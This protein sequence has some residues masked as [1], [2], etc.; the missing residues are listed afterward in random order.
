MKLVAALGLLLLM[1]AGAA[2]AETK[3]A[4]TVDLPNDV[5]TMD[6]Q[7]QWDTDSYSV[8]RNVFDN[9]VSRHASGTIVRQIATAWHYVNDRTIVFDLRSDVHF[10]DGSKLTPNDVVFSIARITNPAFHSPQLSQFDQIA[11][12][13][14]SGPAQVTLHTKRP[15][16]VLLAQLVKL[17]II[18]K[19]Y[20]QKVGDGGLN[21]HPIGSGPY[22]LRSWQHGVQSVLDANPSYWRG[23]P[24]FQ[25]VIFR[26]VP[27]ESTRVADLRAGHADIIR[28][29]SPD[30]AQALK[31]D[32]QLQV[33]ATPTERLGYLF[34]NT[35]WGP[36]KDLRVRQAMALAIDREA[37]ISALLEGY[38]KP[39][40]EMLTPASFGYG[41]A[42]KPWPFDPRRARALIAEAHAKGA[43]LTFLTSPAYD[44]RITEA[45]QQMLSD[46]GLTVKI[47][48]VDMPTFLHDREGTPAAAQSLA[49]GRWSCACQDADGTIW[50]LFHSGIIW[51][52]YSNPAFDKL[53]DAARGTLDPKQ[54]LADYVQAFAILHHDVPAV[55]LFQ[56]YAIYGARRGLH[57]KPT[58]NEAF[59][60]IDMSWH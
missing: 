19:A 45:V 43:T 58:P 2:R 27:D 1:G 34:V 16:P 32:R 54:R 35:Q 57:W 44:R 48:E 28:Q 53:V 21:A 15:Y 39:V 52:K 24:P 42:I 8:Y 25:T 46:V 23:K 55:P 26:V 14:V 49:Q 38:G 9:L 33:L 36:G 50:P 41:L 40:R 13:E 56:D 18:P 12:A 10:Q 37:I 51:S 5:A 17:S 3:N 31:S 29:L 6:P 20:V 4:L 30:D 59:F 60:V 47:V 22:K 11:S 7:L